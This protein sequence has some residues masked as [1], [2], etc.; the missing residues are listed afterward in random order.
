MICITKRKE[1]QDNLKYFILWS[2]KS[3]T[4]EP[5]ENIYSVSILLEYEL[6]LDRTIFHIVSVLNSEQVLVTFLNLTQRSYNLDP[7]V[8]NRIKTLLEVF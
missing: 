5:L 8:L 3:K 7:R 2:D 1:E 4:W 6:E